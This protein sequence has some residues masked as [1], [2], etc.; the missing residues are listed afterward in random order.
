MKENV[1]SYLFK[2]CPALG[3]SSWLSYRSLSNLQRKPST[4]MNT[5]IL[6]NA[7]TNNNRS[8][9]KSSIPSLAGN[10]VNMPFGPCLGRSQRLSQNTESRPNHLRMRFHVAYFR[11]LSYWTSTRIGADRLLA[12]FSM[13]LGPYLDMFGPFVGVGA[14]NYMLF[15]AVVAG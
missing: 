9:V 14:S 13:V 3:V 6:S 12:W 1:Y 11:P 5:S 15:K 10:L 4:T 7:W 8:V 2:W